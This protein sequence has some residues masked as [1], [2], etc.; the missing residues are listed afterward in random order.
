[1]MPN[2]I[3]EIS[4]GGRRRASL[5]GTRLPST[6]NIGGRPALRWISE[7]PPR[8]ATCK[9]SLSSIV[10]PTSRIGS[11]DN[12]R[13]RRVESSRQ[14]EI[15]ATVRGRRRVSDEKE[16]AVERHDE[17]DCSE[18]HSSREQIALVR[19]DRHRQEDE[20]ER[21]QFAA[22]LVP[23]RTARRLDRGALL[24]VFLLLQLL[25]AEEHP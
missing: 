7:A 16:V 5:R 21:D 6:R 15:C 10:P 17:P 3:R 20:R 9:I 11:D 13:K 2:A 12:S 18:R 1:M 14:A 24:Q 25:H 4:S 8:S 19:Q 23:V 22:Q